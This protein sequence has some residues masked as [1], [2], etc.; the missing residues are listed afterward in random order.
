M[1]TTNAHYKLPG[2]QIAYF[3]GSQTVVRV[4]PVVLSVHHTGFSVV[5][6]RVAGGCFGLVLGYKFLGNTGLFC[7][8]HSKKKKKPKCI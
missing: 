6:L 4:P 1:M 5:F 3:N 2:T 8:N 7:L